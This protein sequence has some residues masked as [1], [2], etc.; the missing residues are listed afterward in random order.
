MNRISRKAWKKYVDALSKINDKAAEE[1][2]QWA[3]TFCSDGSG[4]IDY[5]NLLKAYDKFDRSFT[6]YCYLVAREYGMASAAM[7]A[8]MYDATAE[9]EGALVP[10]AEMADTA[11]YEEV[12]KTVNGVMKTSKNIDEMSGAVSRLVKKAG[13]D[14]TLKNAYRDRAEYAWIPSGDTCAFCLALAANGW[15]NIGE[16]TIRK[17]Y[18]HAEHI[19]SNC[20]CA[21]AVRFTQDTQVAGYD[22]G[23]YMDT[24]NEAAEESGLIEPGDTV[25]RRYV[26]EGQQMGKEVINALRRQN[27]ARNREEIL[28]QKASAYEKRKEL[29]SSKAE[30]LKVD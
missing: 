2:R 29:N 14:T 22:P 18:Q 7:A 30:E 6:D 23:R 10:A 19:H 8:Q 1:I 3:E 20:D 4:G 12:A 26:G 17:G 11:T 5:D 13:C 21:Y 27:Y 15:V 9:L 16:R 25:E 24:I 28:K